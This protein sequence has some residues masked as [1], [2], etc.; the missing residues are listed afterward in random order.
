[1]KDE[2][3][4]TGLVKSGRYPRIKNNGAV[5]ISNDSGSS[6]D[7]AGGLETV[8][9]TAVLVGVLSL[10]TSLNGLPELE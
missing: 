10:L 6:D 5:C 1:M 9:G 8:F 2:E 4:S 3:E 7:C